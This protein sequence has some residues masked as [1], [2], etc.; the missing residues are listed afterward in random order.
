MIETE[1]LPGNAPRAILAGTATLARLERAL[2][3]AC[4]DLQLERLMPSF[5]RFEPNRISLN[6]KRHYQCL[7]FPN[8]PEGMLLPSVTTVLSSTA[9]VAKIMALMNW[10]K[11]VGVE[12]AN[13]RTRLAANRGTW[14][15]AILE[16]WFGEED[17]EHHLDKAPDWRPYFNV[18]E[19]FLELIDEPILV[20]SSVAWWKPDIHMGY[21]GTL[22]ML[23]KMTDGSIALIDWKTSFKEKPDNQLSDYK[24]QLGAYSQAAE[25]MYDID[26]EQAFCVIAVY[27][28]EDEKSE[29][30]LQLLQMDGFELVHQQRVME[31]TVKRYFNEHYPGGKAFALT[32]D[33]G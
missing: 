15:H 17:I 32:T 18:A 31:D 5:E 12:E 8:V 4:Y 1:Q 2:I 26:I 19:P 21:S 22:D 7:G 24:K 6:G 10:R 27:D 23:A 20:E 9:P 29:P 25:Q 30:C 11:R 3:L 13:R 33:K 28:P 14:L 16:D